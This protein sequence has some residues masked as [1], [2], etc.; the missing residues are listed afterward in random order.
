MRRTVA[1]A[2]NHPNLLVLPFRLELIRPHQSPRARSEIDGRF[3]VADISGNYSMIEN[4]QGDL[5]SCVQIAA[6][7]MRGRSRLAAMWSLDES[8]LVRNT[9]QHQRCD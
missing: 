4:E 5:K 1:G 3:R 9:R 2:C 8:V 7:M 6:V